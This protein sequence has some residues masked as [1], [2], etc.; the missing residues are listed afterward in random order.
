MQASFSSKNSGTFAAPLG[1]LSNG[2]D[3][4]MLIT[5]KNCQVGGC[6]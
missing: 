6:V 5:S 3:A 2:R 4:A 1:H